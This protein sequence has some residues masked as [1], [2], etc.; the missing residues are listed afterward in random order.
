MALLLP[1]SVNLTSIMLTG[2]G[3]ALCKAKELSRV[4]HGDEWRLNY[5]RPSLPAT[6]NQLYI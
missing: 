6:E 4:R 2:N 1:L 3:N 5:I